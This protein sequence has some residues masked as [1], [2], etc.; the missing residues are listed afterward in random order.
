[1]IKITL[2]IYYHDGKSLTL[3][4]MNKYERM[5]K[6]ALNKLKK[7]YN[8]LIR[9]LSKGEAI[10]GQ[11]RAKYTIFYKNPLSDAPNIVSVIE[12]LLMDG[13]QE[14]GKIQEDNCKF[15]MGAEWEI[16]GMDKANPRVEVEVYE[17][18]KVF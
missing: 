2:P 17:V 16:G 1:V 9:Y 5:N 12:K 18:V 15:Y 7:H 6:H 14:C 4:G 11:Y 8:Q 10:S 13:L 3:V